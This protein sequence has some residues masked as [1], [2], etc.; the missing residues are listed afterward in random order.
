MD[1]HSAALIAFLAQIAFSEAP[2]AGN[3]LILELAL[4]P[5]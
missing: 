4:F 1:I 2:L 5:A 3:P